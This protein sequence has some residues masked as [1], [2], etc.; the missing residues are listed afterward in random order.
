[1]QDEQNR[2]ILG[3]RFE[4]H[5]VQ[6]SEELW[7]T[8]TTQLDEKKN[9]KGIIWWWIGGLAATVVLAIGL[10]Q[11][12]AGNNQESRVATAQIEQK[13]HQNNA[14]ETALKNNL[15]ELT[16]ES[17][18]E[19]ALNGEDDQLAAS[20]GDN[21]QA[22]EL[23]K[24]V[25]QEHSTAQINA[26]E[27]KHKGEEKLL[28]KAVLT[29]T[30]EQTKINQPANPDEIEQDE[31]LIVRQLPPS[32]S[33]VL[34]GLEAPA[35]LANSSIVVEKYPRVN[36]WELGVNCGA[37]TSFSGEYV[38]KEDALSDYTY[39]E[40]VDGSIVASLPSEFVTKSRE[41]IPLQ[42]QFLIGYQ[43]N[44]RLTLQS[45]I[46]F[47]RSKTNYTNGQE[48]VFTGIQ[49]P[50]ALQFNI[51]Q[52]YHWGFF[53]KPG[54]SGE[55][56]LLQKTTPAPVL[57]VS[58]EKSD[59]KAVTDLNYLTATTFDFGFF[60]AFSERWQIQ[61]TPGA[62]YYFISNDVKKL[63]DTRSFYLGGKIGLVWTLP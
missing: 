24:P 31:K 40:S 45:G 54:V 13:S 61:C 29:H 25:Q 5:E 52:K 1:M 14:K 47:Q 22:S 27:S 39:T 41:R 4:G 50:I 20:T 58:Y 12:F 33:N 3:G 8:I 18:L 23:P 16:E 7:S 49:L 63:N 30:P 6:P 15:P 57:N 9:R 60:Y 48:S 36:R 56:N 17:N 42:L 51:V 46:G 38:K 10:R 19:K 55:L 2:G 34:P 53:L 28:A 62:K 32:Q 44:K 11:F 21:E 35:T 37:F 26:P 43:F 59:L